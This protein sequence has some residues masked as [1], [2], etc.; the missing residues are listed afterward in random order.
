MRQ[1]SISMAYAPLS[2]Y[3]AVD[4]SPYIDIMDHT[5]TCIPAIMSRFKPQMSTMHIYRRSL[6]KFPVYLRENFGE[7]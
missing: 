2:T 5:R 1:L 4:S 7:Y 3:Q 6:L